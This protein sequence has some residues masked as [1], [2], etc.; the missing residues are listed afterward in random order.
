MRRLYTFSSLDSLIALALKADIVFNSK[1][2]KKL[3][4]EDLYEASGELLTETYYEEIG[5]SKKFGSDIC[6]LN[7]RLYFKKDTNVLARVEVVLES[8]VLKNKSVSKTLPNGKK[9]LLGDRPVK[10]GKSDFTLM[11]KLVVKNGDISSVPAFFDKMIE[12]TTKMMDKS[13][14]ENPGVNSRSYGKLTKQ[15]AKFMQSDKKS[16]IAFLTKASKLKN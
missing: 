2:S 11:G 9:L 16:V 5:L 4:K 8:F 7:Y 1:E 13:L 6:K 3:L 12:K 14:K 15:N 10:S